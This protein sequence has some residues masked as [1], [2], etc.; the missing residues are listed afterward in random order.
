MGVGHIGKLV[1]L[2]VVQVNR[3]T[4]DP[5]AL[6]H[7]T[8]ITNPMESDFFNL[9]SRYSAVAAA[10]MLGQPDTVAIENELCISV[11][12]RLIDG[13]LAPHPAFAPAQ[14]CQQPNQCYAS[15]RN[16]CGNRTDTAQYKSQKEN[17]NGRGQ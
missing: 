10:D 15:G 16:Q 13:L 12:I 1:I 8:E 2:A 17:G 7:F 14:I 6:L 4:M 3:H 11:E 9:S 5:L